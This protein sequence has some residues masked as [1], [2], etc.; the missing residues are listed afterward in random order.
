MTVNGKKVKCPYCADRFSKYANKLYTY[1]GL[2]EHIKHKHKI[3]TAQEASTPWRKHACAQIDLDFQ[4][5]L[6]NRT[7]A[8]KEN[9]E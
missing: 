5:S 9:N 1:A 6:L 2:A 3:V 4:G 8:T 7:P